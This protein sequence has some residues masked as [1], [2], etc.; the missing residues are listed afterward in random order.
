MKRIST[1]I[2]ILSLIFS[3]TSFPFAYA[4]EDSW[5]TLEPLSMEREG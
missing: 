1:V 3:I 4:Q 2:L 5:T